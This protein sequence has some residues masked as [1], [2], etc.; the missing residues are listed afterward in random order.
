MCVRARVRV[1]VRTAFFLSSPLKGHP[2]P[3]VIQAARSWLICSKQG[4]YM[5]DPAPANT[6]RD[7]HTGDEA[8]V[9]GWLGGVGGRLEKGE[10]VD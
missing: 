8:G 9:A 5:D 1:R 4:R 10:W 7:D 3:T 2:H 6:P